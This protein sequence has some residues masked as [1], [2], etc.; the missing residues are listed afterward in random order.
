VEINNQ[1]AYL[2]GENYTIGTSIYDDRHVVAFTTF[3]YEQLRG[4]KLAAER[5]GLACHEVEAI[6]FD[7]ANR[8]FTDV[9]VRN[10][11]TRKD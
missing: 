11:K 2:M 3:F 4:I 8:L 10:Y 6:F 5:A 7:N 1:Y 9:A